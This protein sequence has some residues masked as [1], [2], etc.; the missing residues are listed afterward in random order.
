MCISILASH[1]RRLTR[2]G[3]LGSQPLTACTT[4]ILS[5]RKRIFFPLHSDPQISAARI[6]GTISKMAMFVA[7]PGKEGQNSAHQRS[8]HSIPMPMEPDAS[9]KNSTWGVHSPRQSSETLTQVS[10]VSAHQ[11]R[12]SCLA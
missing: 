6:K 2:C 9:A 3:S 10:K 11:L 8:P 12:S 5:E 4:A 1:F 7:H